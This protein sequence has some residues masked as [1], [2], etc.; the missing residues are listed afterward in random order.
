MAA[1]NSL[2]CFVVLCLQLC[3]TYPRNLYIPRCA[4][5]PH[6][7]GSSKFR[8]RGRL[9]V[10]SYLHRNNVSMMKGFESQAMCWYILIIVI[11]WWLVQCW[12]TFFIKF[13]TRYHE[14]NWLHQN[15]QSWVFQIAILE[16]IGKRYFFI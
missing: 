10:L 6:I 15:M 8:S 12:L 16:Y 3:D 13:R 14:L 1:Y 5:T 2:T 11:R 4:K 7:L 9:P